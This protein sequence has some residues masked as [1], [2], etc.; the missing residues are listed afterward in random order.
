MIKLST[1]IETV[2][3]TTFGARMLRKKSQFSKNKNIQMIE[4]ALVII[5][6]SFA[7]ASVLAWIPWNLSFCYT[8]FHEKKVIFWYQQEVY[9]TK[10]IISGTMHFLLI[11]EN[12][13]CH[14]MKCNGMTSFM[15]F[16]VVHMNWV[17]VYIRT[18]QCDVT[19]SRQK[20]SKMVQGWI[21]SLQKETKQCRD[22]TM[23]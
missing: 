3:Y 8:L 19:P 14:E 9:F 7:F 22:V 5:Q 21:T 15:E 13:F 17:F 12:A 4:V 16:M 10:Y 23:K 6:N 20:R 2:L 18:A 1:F 11:S